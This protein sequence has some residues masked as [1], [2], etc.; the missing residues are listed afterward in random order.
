MGSTAW[1]PIARESLAN[2]AADATEASMAQI[3]AYSVIENSL[4][5]AIG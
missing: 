1:H 2:V 5:L 3:Y 4:Y